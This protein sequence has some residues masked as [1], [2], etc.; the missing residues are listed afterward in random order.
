MRWILGL[1]MVLLFSGSTPVA[2]S[3]LYELDGKP[4]FSM[5]HPLGWSVVVERSEELAVKPDGQALMPTLITAR[6]SVG[7]LWYGIWVCDKI[8]DFDDAQH[9]LASLTEH[10]FDNVTPSKFETG[11]YNGM[12]M[13]Y[14]EGTAVY[15]RPEANAT[16]R[17]NVDFF[18]AFFKPGDKGVGIALYVG[19]PSA[20]ERYRD[21][22][23]Q[24]LQ[25][26]RPV[27]VTSAVRS[28]E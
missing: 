21:A 27:I 16:H 24:S 8:D 1:L 22:L 10:V 11:V 23:A 20:T 7:Q 15:L 5:S 28:Y 17:E 25:S 6:P 18:A 2:Q 13:R 19:L 26:I 4:L 9:Y 3:F 12:D 14:Y